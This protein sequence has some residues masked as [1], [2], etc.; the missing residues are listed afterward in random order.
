MGRKPLKLDHEA[1]ESLAA[2]GLTQRQAATELRLNPGTL[3]GRMFTDPPLKA[4]WMRGVERA[5]RKK[6]G[7]PRAGSVNEQK[8]LDAVHEGHRTC[9]AIKAHTGLLNSDFMTAIERLEV[10]GHIKSHDERMLT[11]YYLRD[12]EFPA[13]SL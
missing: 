6:Q 4:A 8:V 11:H 13:A 2:R 12:E 1:I 7:P 5:R 10:A 9:A 3:T